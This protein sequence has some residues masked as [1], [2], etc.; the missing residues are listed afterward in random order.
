MFK[1]TAILSAAALMIAGSA[2]AQNQ[3]AQSK[4]TIVLVHG[5]FAESSSWNEVISRLDN[6]GFRVIAPANALRSVAG[7]AQ[8]VSAVVKSIKGPV[9]LVGHSYGGPVITEAANGN[10]NVVALVYVS[11]F[12]PDKGESSLSLSSKYPGST[13][14]DTLLPVDLPNGDQDL[15]IQPGKFHAQ[16]AADVPI[17]KARLMA[18]TQRAVTMSALSEPSGSPSWKTVPSYAIYGSADLNIPP[19]TLEF[20]ASRA[21][22]RKTV[23]VKGASHVVMVSHPNKVAKLIELAASDN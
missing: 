20:M 4:P 22:S 13:L 18:E 14:G 9:V 5:A 3:S 23:V 8:S 11:A 16:F 19:A 6:D 17:A 1:I 2:L 12:A 21:Q 10:D 15:Y 7:D